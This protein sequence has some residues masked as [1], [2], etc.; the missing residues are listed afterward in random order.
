MELNN[1]LLTHLEQLQDAHNDGEDW[2]PVE[3]EDKKYIILYTFATL[4]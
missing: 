1:R 4:Y 2:G 3:T